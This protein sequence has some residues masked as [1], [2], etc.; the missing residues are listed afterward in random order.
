[1]QQFV[2]GEW[3]AL[4]L[5]QEFLDQLLADSEEANNL[6]KDFKKQANLE[7][8]SNIFEFSTIILYFEWLLEI[9]EVETGKLS[10]NIESF[11]QDSI[12]EEVKRALEKIDKYFIDKFFFVFFWYP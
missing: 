4:E 5:V 11:T 7:L 8:N 1:M 6:V 2:G 12:L 3:N 10:S 9:D